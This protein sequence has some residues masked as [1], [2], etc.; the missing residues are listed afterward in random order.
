V[1]SLCLVSSYQ[2]GCNQLHSRIGRICPNRQIFL[3]T[4]FSVPLHLGAIN[5]IEFSFPFTLSVSR[6]YLFKLTWEVINLSYLTFHF[7]KNKKNKSLFIVGLIYIVL[8]RV[9]LL[10]IH[11]LYS[12]YLL[13][14]L[15]RWQGGSI[16]RLGK[17]CPPGIQEV[18]VHERKQVVR[19]IHLG[20]QG[21]SL[22]L[23]CELSHPL[24]LLLFKSPY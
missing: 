16:L 7:E 10:V 5:T 20:N 18:K 17:Q 12:K 22:P 6:F 8:E 1:G 14:P 19:H 9:G 24:P 2:K 13:D 11:L 15:A 4:P 21:N 23:Q 3:I